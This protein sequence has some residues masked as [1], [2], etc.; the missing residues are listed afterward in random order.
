M[1]YIIIANSLTLAC[2]DYENRIFGDEYV[3][4]RNLNL[5]ELDDAFTYIFLIECLVK[6]LA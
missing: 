4:I 5:A 6:I 2:T 1:T 3:S